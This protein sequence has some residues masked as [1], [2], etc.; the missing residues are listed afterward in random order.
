MS[1]PEA[2]PTAEKDTPSYDELVAHVRYLSTAVDLLRQVVGAIM[3]SDR[4]YEY[5][6]SLRQIDDEYRRI[7]ASTTCVTSSEAGQS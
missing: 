5:A 1:E 6:A 3:P 2:Q 4:A 7:L